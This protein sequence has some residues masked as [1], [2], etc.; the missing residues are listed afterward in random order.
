[1]RSPTEQAA[2]SPER[3]AAAERLPRRNWM[4]RRH[5]R[6]GSAHL[7]YTFRR[8]LLAADV[9]AIALA[10]GATALVVRGAQAAPDAS[11]WVLVAASVPV[12][13]TVAH[14]LEL[15]HLAER[16]VE[17]TFADELAPTLLATTVWAWLLLLVAELSPVE[18]G[19]TH[20][21][22]VLW[23]A[24][25]AL[26][27]VARAGARKLAAGR[28]WFRRRAVVVGDALGA[29]LVLRRLRR[30]PEWGLDPVAVVKTQDPGGDGPVLERLDDDGG[31]EREALGPS[32]PDPGELTARMVALGADRVILAG[33]QFTVAEQTELIRELLREEI[34]VDHVAGEAEALYSTAVL[35]HF[36]G[37]PVLS[38]QAS[39]PGRG[40]RALKRVVDVAL[41]ATGLVLTSPLLAYAAVRIKLDSPGPVLFRQRRVGLRGREFTML[42]LRTMVVGADAARDELRPLSLHGGSGLFKLRDDPRVTR[43]G[44][45]LRRYSIDELPQLWNVLRG[46]M[47]L[48]GPRP[49]PLDE[50]PNVG[51]RYAERAMMRPG[52]TGPWQTQGRSEIPFEDMLKLDYAYVVGWSMR[53]DLRLLVRTLGAVLRGR[54][55]Y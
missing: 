52:I 27:L 53:E 2:D 7:G 40:A 34:A 25:C 1:M 26:V 49:L 46:D 47:S 9:I 51:D 32:G 3:Q 28:A 13:V 23:A 20:A 54:G 33:G 8:L 30:H 48:V 11:W 5:P 43:V 6:L 39:A 22:A 44:R 35:H 21:L 38:I 18:G 16:R 15:Y 42:K 4:A 45:K 12:W 41:A 31:S 29:G 50:A 17:H 36:E 14:A 55:A 37:I 24:A 19:G 10:A